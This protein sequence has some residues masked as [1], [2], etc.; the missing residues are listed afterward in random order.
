MRKEL[1]SCESIEIS[2]LKIHWEFKHYKS[3]FTVVR[4]VA[5]MLPRCD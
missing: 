5:D 3:T 2:E 4:D 1:H